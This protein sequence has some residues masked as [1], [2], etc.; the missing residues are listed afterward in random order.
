[1]TING[2]QEEV[3]QAV[4]RYTPIA[5]LT[6]WPALTIPCGFSRDGLPIGFQIIARPFC[7]EIILRI[8]RAYE[9]SQSWHELHPSSWL[10]NAG[11]MTTNDG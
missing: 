1:V 11:R 4:T 2:Q 6:G 10:D 9:Q 7:E 5:S 3:S 8:G